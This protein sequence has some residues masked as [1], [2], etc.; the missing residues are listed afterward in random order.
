MSV[1]IA[2]RVLLA[3]LR[4]TEV[5]IYDYAVANEEVL[6][7]KSII[8]IQSSANHTQAV[9]TKFVKRFHV[10]FY[11]S[12][13]DIE[14]VLLSYKCG[15]LYTI[16]YGERRVNEPTLSINGVYKTALH[17]VFS[18][19]DP[20]A[21]TYVPISKYLADKYNADSYVP[22]MISLKLD[23][24]PVNELLK[25]MRYKEN[26][27]IPSNAIVFGRHGGLETFN[28]DFVHKTIEKIVNSTKNIY[29]LFVNTFK[30]INHKQVIYLPPIVSSHQKIK[31]IMACDAMLHARADGE[32]FGI[33]C[34]EF[35]VC[36]KP[37][38]TCTCGDTSH[39]DILG[40]RCITYSNQQQL[41]HILLNF[42][43]IKIKKEKELLLNN[44]HPGKLWDAYSKEYSA[45]PVIK[46]WW[47]YLIEPCL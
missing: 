20:H 9:I 23:S 7:N 25:G 14:R 30:F 35:S 26:L 10:Y 3:S 17:C 36:N 4:G 6:G 1:T 19:Q 33:A 31:F 8:L 15:V 43:N 16:A 11:D 42:L 28:I 27:G 5:A 24:H 18:M 46:M 2:F 41:E 39:I 37:V 12:I 13:A 47:K 29:F 40:E 38:I 45:E 44:N 34:G 22:H 32:T 21:D